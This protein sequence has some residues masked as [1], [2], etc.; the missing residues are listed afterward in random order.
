MRPPCRALPRDCGD[1]GGGGV[2]AP[3][4]P[5]AAAA[6]ARAALGARAAGPADRAATPRTASVLKKFHP[7]T[8]R[9]AGGLG[10]SRRACLPVDPA[11][12]T[13]R[14]PH[15]R[16]TAQSS[17]GEDPCNYASAKDVY[18]N[19]GNSAKGDSFRTLS[20]MAA[21]DLTGEE[22]YAGFLSLY[23]PSVSFADDFSRAALDG[24]GAFTG[25]SDMVRMTAA[26][27]NNFCTL[28]MYTNHEVHEALGKAEAG[29][30]LHATDNKYW[31]EVFAFFHGLDGTDA[32]YEVATKRDADF[33]TAHAAA[34]LAAITA[35]Q[36]A[37][38]DADRDALAAK[39]AEFNKAAVAT[40]IQAALKY[41]YIVQAAGT[42]PESE[43]GAKSWAEG[44]T[45]WRCAAGAVAA[46][47]LAAARAVDSLFTVDQAA[48]DLDAQLYCKIEA[49]LK[50]A[51]PY[52]LTWADLGTLSESH[53]ASVTIPADFCD[54]VDTGVP[55][56]DYEED[57]PVV[58]ED[59]E[60]HPAPSKPT[61][62]YDYEEGHP[63]S[64]DEDYEHPIEIEEDVVEPPSSDE[65][66]GAAGAGA[67]TAAIM[68]AAAAALAAMSV[69]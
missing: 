26:K 51:L 45:Y 13:H 54:G 28:L 10:L 25:K 33:G 57:H 7:A 15:A 37:A 8:L 63:E 11:S 56:V 62:D 55:A 32:P 61:T 9:L 5:K 4:A 24:A 49:R 23:G 29:V 53:G 30:A 34:A 36:Q 1:R 22:F 52:G 67:V 59:Y 17:L 6:A 38:R 35:G 60:A 42:A 16:H 20:G 27:K 66:S 14:L 46:V 48:A 50:T 58:D 64:T 43:E 39:A 69:E 47:D 44:Y 40:F 18:E 41:S 31:D 21:R 19:G 68:A 3:E 2:R 12:D 65:A